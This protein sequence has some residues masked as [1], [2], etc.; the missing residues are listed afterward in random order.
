M[1]RRCKTGYF[2]KSPILC[3]QITSTSN[4]DLALEDGI[5]FRCSVGYVL[6]QNPTHGT[7]QC[8]S[9]HEYA[10]NDCYSFNY[11]KTAITDATILN[12]LN[13]DSTMEKA[14]GTYINS[15]LVMGGAA[16]TTNVHNC[17][18]CNS[19][20][21]TNGTD[22]IY[23]Y[24]WN[25]L[26]PAIPINYCIENS[27]SASKTSSLFGS[28]YTPIYSDNCMIY[29]SKGNC[30]RCDANYYLTTVDFT[31]AAG[32]GT[33]VIRCKARDATIGGC[34]QAPTAT[35]AV[36]LKPVSFTHDAT[37]LTI[38]KYEHCTLQKVTG[39]TINYDTVQGLEVLQVV[40][41]TAVFTEAE[42]IPLKCK[43]F[44]TILPTLGAT[45]D[46]FKYSNVN[47]FATLVTG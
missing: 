38:N 25:A 18:V 14:M 46:V 16:I 7:K 19:T 26:T 2:P 33:G 47:P 9:P 35:K 32:F 37:Y 30:F 21:T 41:S 13:L 20:Y 39:N 34:D 43:S 11:D 45:L 3:Q 40:A 10:S 8:M 17:L 42:F 12:R 27:A 15:T 36:S 1:C 31:V 24:N 6:V 44:G 29:G 5:C 23:L 28:E 22:Y 4:C